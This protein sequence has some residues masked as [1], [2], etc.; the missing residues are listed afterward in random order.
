MRVLLSGGG[1]GGHINPALAIAAKIKEK[2]PEAVIEFIGTSRGLE[3]TL[4]P[5]EGYKLHLVNVRGFKRKLCAETFVALKE[6]VT[7]VF[8]AKKIIK[9]FKPDVVIGTGGYV[10]WPVLKAAAQMKIP[11]AVHEQ[12]AF[13]GVTNKMLAKYVDKV[14]ISFEAARRYFPESKVVLTGNPI[15]DEMLRADRISARAQLG[16]D[17]DTPVI[18]SYGGSLGARRVNETSIEVIERFSENAKVFHIHATGKIYYEDTKERLLKRGYTETQKGELRKGNV[19]VREYIYNMPSLMSAADVLVCRAG[20]MTMSEVSA[21][22]KAAVIIPSPN[23]TDNHQYKNAKVLADANS[24][25]LIEE[26]NLNG[27]TLVKAVK[28][29]CEDKKKRQSIQENVR[30]FAVCDSLERIYSVIE[31]ITK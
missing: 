20:A 3:T 21:M 8:E 24:G 14:M 15:K 13:A 27:E 19:V 16:V 5:R 22:G 2:H 28:E 23:V 25:I 9:E 26:S 1:T 11:T 10:C 18:L 31:E 4:V 12:N 7:S 30:Q 6:A 17:D 29:L